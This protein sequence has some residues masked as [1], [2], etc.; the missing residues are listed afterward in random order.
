MAEHRVQKNQIYQCAPERCVPTM[1][2]MVT[3]GEVLSRLQRPE[4]EFL[5][6]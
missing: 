5:N 4:P 6:F 3:L 1:G 2:G